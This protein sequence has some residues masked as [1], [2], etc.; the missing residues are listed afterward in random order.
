MPDVNIDIMGIGRTTKSTFNFVV[1]LI[2][3]ALVLVFSL[4]FGISC[5]IIP[6]W[7][8]MSMDTIRGH[9]LRFVLYVVL[10]LVA[11]F[12][13]ISFF[14]GTGK[15]FSCLITL[16]VVLGILGHIIDPACSK[17]YKVYVHAN[18]GGR[19]YV[20]NAKLWHMKERIEGFN[21]HSGSTTY[22]VCL[23]DLAWIYIGRST[24]VTKEKLWKLEWNKEVKSTTCTVHFDENKKLEGKTKLLG[25]KE[26]MLKGKNR[27][28]GT[29][30]LNIGDIYQITFS[31]WR[32]ESY[33]EFR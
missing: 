29:V 1:I 5:L 20:K 18:D 6:G 17:G 3:I 24:T 33:K 27:S 32:P 28:G 15:F 11:F 2:I 31:P 26:V 10:S 12:L 30:R 4:I 13:V 23:G 21:L 14:R 8:E 9:T 16:L 25:G 22:R 19:Y 7:T